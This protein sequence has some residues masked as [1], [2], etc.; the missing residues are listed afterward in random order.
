MALRGKGLGKEAI[1]KPNM[2]SLPSRN[3]Q[4]IG[5]LQKIHKVVQFE[6]RRQEWNV[7]TCR[8]AA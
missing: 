3:P 2:W 7:S 1:A 5:G 8:I 6:V 4:Q